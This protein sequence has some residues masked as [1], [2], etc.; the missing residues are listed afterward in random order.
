M[1]SSKQIIEE[2]KFYLA[3]DDDMG[4]AAKSLGISRRTLCLHFK[5][6]QQINE[7]LYK[8]VC[9][10]N[11]QNKAQQKHPIKLTEEQL[12]KEAES[13]LASDL[14]I[15]EMAKTLGVSEKTLKSHFKKLKT[16]SPKLYEEIEKR[17]KQSTISQEDTIEQY[18][19]EANEYLSGNYT[20]QQLASIL[21]MDESTLRSHFKKI[22]D[23]NPKLYIQIEEKSRENRFHDK[24]YDESYIEEAIEYIT[25]DLT[26]E[27]T[28][29]K[30][31]ISLSTLQNHFQRVKEMDL[32]LNEK[33]V[34]K[35]KR[36]I[37][38]G[39]ITGGQRGKATRRYSDAEI[40]EIV[41][42][43]ISSELTYE[44]AST[45]LEIPKSTIYELTHSDAVSKELKDQLDMVAEANIRNCSVGYLIEES[46]KRGIR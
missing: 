12:I 30:L 27:Q 16:I 23:Y 36:Q 41:H 38:N 42:I 15:K 5:R 40:L 19:R 33:I 7:N 9:E 37:H 20:L 25:N 26:M 32:D 1:D 44:E 13:F 6:L 10:R 24:E 28:A 21:G 35:T 3:G 4:T 34:E 2:A 14:T 22:K 43:I 8:L 17:E 46:E 31:G 45:L 18:I 11:T 39:T 29:K